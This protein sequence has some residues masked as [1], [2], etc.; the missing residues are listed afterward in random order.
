MATLGLLQTLGPSIQCLL[1]VL[2]YHEPLSTSRG[3]GFVLIWAALAIYSA[4]GWRVMRRG[5]RAA[6]A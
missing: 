6:A 1:G 3:A 5:C 2:V 4:A